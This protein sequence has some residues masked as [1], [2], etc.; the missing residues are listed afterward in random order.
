VTIL[1]L[2]Y[3]ISFASW[4]GPEFGFG[5]G[6][7]FHFWVK[8]SILLMILLLLLSLLLWNQYE[9]V[10]V[11]EKKSIHTEQHSHTVLSLNGAALSSAFVWWCGLRRH[12][13]VVFY[14]YKQHSNI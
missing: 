14:T 7:Y 8:S 1:F 4:L 11:Y 6:N 3:L 2:F 12:L 10:G 5:F 9:C 13:A